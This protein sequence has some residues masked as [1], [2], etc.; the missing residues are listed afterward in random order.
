MCCCRW[1]FSLCLSL[2]ILH[3]HCQ[4]QESNVDETDTT[5]RSYLDSTSFACTHLCIFSSV[6]FGHRCT[7]DTGQLLCRDPSCYLFWL[8]PPPTPPST[9]D[10]GNHQAVVHLD[11]FVIL[12][13]WYKWNHVSVTFWEF[14]F[15]QHN[16]LE[17]HPSCVHR[18][19]V[20]FL[21]Q[22]GISRFW[23]IHVLL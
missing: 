15:M 13:M 12:R 9:S 6:Y 20:A 3:H 18:W 17:I 2:N 11:N 8:Q 16:S 10:P 23:Y 19:F 7:E 14:F 22:R 21:S 5:Q 4:N 1:S